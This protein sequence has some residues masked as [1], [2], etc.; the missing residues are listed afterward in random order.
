MAVNEPTGTRRFLLCAP[1]V[2]TLQRLEAPALERLLERRRG[3][4][5]RGD[6]RGWR[7]LLGR[8]RRRRVQ[9]GREA[10]ADTLDQIEPLPQCSSATATRILALGPCPSSASPSI[11][12]SE[13][14]CEMLPSRSLLAILDPQPIASCGGVREGEQLRRYVVRIRFSN[15]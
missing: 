9:P 8:L 5:R 10:I 4:R 12:P 1:P 15:C 3:A 13:I 11:L 6:C 14:H 2:L 7:D